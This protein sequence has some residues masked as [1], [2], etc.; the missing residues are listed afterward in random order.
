MNDRPSFP[1]GIVGAV[2]L[3]ALALPAVADEIEDTITAALEAYRAGDVA[4]AK[5]ELDYVS[6]LLAQQQ[7]ASLGNILPAPFDGW[8]QEMT[9]NEAAAGMAMF[10]GGLSAGA[11]YRKDGDNVEIQVMADSPMITAMMAMFTNPAFAASSGGQL[12]RVG[13]QKVISDPGRRAAGDRPQSLHDQRHGL[14]GG[15]RQGSLLPGH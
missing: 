6:Q 11:D 9:V 10:G 1:S 14:R 4:T 3:T 5:G 2:L 13:G 8:T 15:R 12:K 7:A